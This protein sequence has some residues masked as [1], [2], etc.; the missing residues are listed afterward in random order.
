[1]ILNHEALDGDIG[2][3]LEGDLLPRLSASGRLGAFIHTGYW[4][5][6]DTAKDI[7]ELRATENAS[8]AEGRRPP[9]MI[10]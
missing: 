2:Q 5:A 7:V 9:W 6:V 3:S 1:M 8:A 4:K 10:L